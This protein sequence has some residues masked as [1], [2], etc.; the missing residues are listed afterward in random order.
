MTKNLWSKYNWIF[1]HFST[2][3]HLCSCK[4]IHIAW[5]NSVFLKYWCLFICKPTP[6]FLLVCLN[7]CFTAHTLMLSSFPFVFECFVA[8]QWKSY[9]AEDSIATRNRNRETLSSVFHWFPSLLCCSLSL[10]AAK[11]SVCSVRH[12][13]VRQSVTV[14]LSRVLPCDCS[15]RACLLCCLFLCCLSQCLCLAASQSP[16]DMWVLLHQE[17]ESELQEKRVKK[18]HIWNIIIGRQLML[19]HC[20]NNSTSKNKVVH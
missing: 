18:C 5:D 8:V 20:N 7:V 3:F 17:L 14:F 11:A 1:A 2:R 19:I 6:L 13:S 9:F 15:H 16:P 12:W 10:C 4:V